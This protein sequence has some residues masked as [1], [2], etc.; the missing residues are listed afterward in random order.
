M[1]HI[2]F[3]RPKVWIYKTLNEIISFTNNLIDAGLPNLTELKV[4]EN[5]VLKVDADGTHIYNTEGTEIGT[6][7]DD[8]IVLGDHDGLHIDINTPDGTIISDGDGNHIIEID[9]SNLYFKDENGSNHFKFNS[10]TKLVQIMSP[11]GTKTVDFSNNIIDTINN[12]YDCIKFDGTDLIIKNKL[13]S[14]S[15]IYLTANGMIYI[16]VNGDTYYFTD[17]NFTIGNDNVLKIRTTE[18]SETKLQ[19]LLA[20]IPSSE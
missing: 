2:E 1:K 12:L 5:I 15:G 17:D 6:F 18:L 10:E 20:L 3:I 4:S 9:G 19:Q 8:G 16:K 14:D 11:D 13:S 7:T